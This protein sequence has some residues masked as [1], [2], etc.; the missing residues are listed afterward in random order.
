MVLEPRLEVTGP[1]PPPHA[2]VNGAGEGL[3]HEA[4]AAGGCS[5]DMRARYPPVVDDQDALGAMA[6]IVENTV[7]IGGRNGDLPPQTVYRQR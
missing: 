3:A 7:G 4:G 1:I 5:T 6:G 2:G